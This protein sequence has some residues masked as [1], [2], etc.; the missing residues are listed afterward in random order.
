MA[1]TARRAD[2]EVGGRSSLWVEVLAAG[3]RRRIISCS[4][5][6]W[7]GAGRSGL[8]TSRSTRSE[9]GRRTGAT[10]AGRRALPGRTAGSGTGCRRRTAACSWTPPE[11]PG[12][13][14][15]R[16]AGS[17]WSWSIRSRTERSP[18]TTRCCTPRRTAS[19]SRTWKNTK[20]VASVVYETNLPEGTRRKTVH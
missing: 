18:P 6:G 11:S 15:R 9:C 17:E 4:R 20:T 14:R 19:W 7:T 8:G 10:G 1:R 16:S 13:S 2:G 5:T 3:R 12:W